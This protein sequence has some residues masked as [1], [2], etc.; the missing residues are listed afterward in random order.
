MQNAP[1]SLPI[2]QYYGT[3]RNDV[4]GDIRVETVDGEL[5]LRTGMYDYEL[6]HWHHDVFLV[7]YVTWS[8]PSFSTFAVDEE[9][10]VATFDVFGE[11]F[12]RVAPD[13]G[14]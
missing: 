1:H 3:Y 12:E 8:Y 13:D 7:D 10:I 9:G 11:R 4:L 2:A 5:R 6:S 14:E